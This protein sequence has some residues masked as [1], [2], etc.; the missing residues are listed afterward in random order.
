L[1][2]GDHKAENDEVERQEI[3][4]VEGVVALPGAAKLLKALPMECW[5]VVT[6]ATRAL[7]EVRMRAGGLPLPKNFVTAD[8]ITH[9]KPNPEPYLKGAK[10]LGV[11][12]ADCVVVEDAPAGIRA[13][14][15]AGARVVALRTTAGDA[16]L[17]EAG[18]EWIVEDLS[19]LSVNEDGDTLLMLAKY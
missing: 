3:E 18:A 5:A 2:D 14:K 13:G 15:A 4:D 12:A 1:P 8:D 7:A 19:Q 10:L 17:R 11:A 16:E 9:G 6:S